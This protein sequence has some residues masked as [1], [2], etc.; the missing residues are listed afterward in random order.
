ML[1]HNNHWEIERIG[2][3]YWLIPPP[4]IDP[5]QTPRLMPTTSAALRDLQREHSAG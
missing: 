1:L 5:D 4:D 2:A 3:E